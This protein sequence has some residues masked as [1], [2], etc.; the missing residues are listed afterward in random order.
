[1]APQP[2]GRPTRSCVA[3]T[4]QKIA[5]S[6]KREREI[7]ADDEA[8]QDDPDFEDQDELDHDSFTSPAKRTRKLSVMQHRVRDQV[9]LQSIAMPLRLRQAHVKEP[10]SDVAH[11]QCTRALDKRTSTSADSLDTP[12]KELAVKHFAVPKE[13]FHRLEVVKHGKEDCTHASVVHTL[14]SHIMSL[15]STISAQKTEVEIAK[16]DASSIQTQL[17]KLHEGYDSLMQE[18]RAQEVRLKQLSEEVKESEDNLASRDRTL[19]NVRNKL[20][21]QVGE[22]LALTSGRKNWK[23]DKW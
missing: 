19:L 22:N 15:E 14:R 23:Y 2:R 6:V 17:D 10:E 11:V 8:D 21:E 9:D 1:M 3:N 16:S 13:T 5:A 18:K 12:E 4:N 7:L 20:L